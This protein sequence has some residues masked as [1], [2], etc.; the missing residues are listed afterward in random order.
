MCNSG[1]LNVAA[2][3]I[4]T[5]VDH[6][7]D[8][9][10]RLRMDRAAR[11]RGAVVVEG[12]S[13]QDALSRAFAIDKN[14][15][16]PVAGRAN[17]LRVA[18]ELLTA[19]LPGIT[20]V[21]D[22]DFDADTH[23]WGRAAFLVFY[24]DA[25]LEAMLIHTDVLSRFLELWAS[26]P[27]LAKFGGVDAVRRQL[28]D[29]L[30]PLSAL[31]AASAAKGWG[32]EFKSLPL[33]KL[34]D[35]HT[36]NLALDRLLR[37]LATSSGRSEPELRVAAEASPPTCPHTRRPL[38]SGKDATSILDVA[39]RNAIGNLSKQQ[40]DGGFSR[41]NIHLGLGAGDLVATQFQT[42]LSAA[43]RAASS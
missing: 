32:L 10:S 15:I 26:A 5:S 25:D 27:K 17:V 3:S 43:R 41:R 42:R 31:R 14:D 40:V 4:Q 9:L 35:L 18:S 1:N 20:C 39:L 8:V 29:T 7:T 37:R 23:N 2:V 33:Q 21:A 36:L 6:V 24:D 13:D 28:G 16:F 12:P 30:A 22:R 11:L 38:I 34:V 19:P